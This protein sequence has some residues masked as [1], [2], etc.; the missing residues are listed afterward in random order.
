MKKWSSYASDVSHES[1]D[2][3]IIGSGIGGLTTAALLALNG[4]RVLVLEKHFKIGG[5]THTFRR[6]DYEWDVGLHYIGEV[7]NK[8]S[9]ARKLFDLIS[10]CQLQWSKMDDNY[11][12]IIFPD[13][14]FNYVAPREQFIDD[15]INYFPKEEKAIHTY[16][17]YLDEAVRSARPYFANKALPGMLANITYPFMTGKFFKYANRTTF[18]VISSLSDNPKLMG[19][20]TGQWGNYG[21]PPKKSSFAMHAFVARHYLDGGNYPVGSSRRIAETVADLIESRGGRLV[22][23]AGVKKIVV[24]KEKAI[25]VE[26]E[27]G[28]VLEAPI[29]ISNAGVVNTFDRLLKNK[30][31]SSS[32]LADLESIDQTESYVCLHLGLNKSAKELK[33]NSTNLWVYPGYNHDR[34]VQEFMQ[35]SKNDFPVVYI[36]FPSTKDDEWDKD[37]AGF[38]TIEAITLAHWD[39]YS[40]W[41]DLPWKKRGEVY[42]KEKEKLSQRILDIV[43]QHVHQAKDALAYAELSTPLTVTSLANYSKGEMY[44][45][46]HTPKRFRQKWLKPQTKIKNLFLTGQDITTVGVTSALFS[47]LLTAS[48]VLG[49]NLTTMLK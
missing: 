35:D 24:H 8:W 37:H 31:A 39:E 10:D 42:E 17:Q 34:N 48:A 45:I 38:A 19:V 40:K 18:D 9:A 47:G 11:D 14:T 28:D 49:K 20:L 1:F 21:L 27:N 44:G 46:S 3:I 29:I 23:N 32:P 43:Y 2:A 5:W 26:L 25:G 22:V 16:V 15:M 4:K 30:S 13:R 36:S 41:Q 6:D 7:H 12:R 33:L